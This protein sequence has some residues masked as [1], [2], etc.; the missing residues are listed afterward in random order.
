MATRRRQEEPSRPRRPPATTPEGRENQ[1]IGLAVELAERQL[2]EGT[3]SSQVITHYLKL[4]TSRERLEQE[5]LRHENELLKAKKEALASQARVEELYMEALGA[6]RG[7]Q[8]QPPLEVEGE[9]DD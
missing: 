7:Y 9:Y 6:M 1:L 8:G 5:K 4:G 3:A 2:L